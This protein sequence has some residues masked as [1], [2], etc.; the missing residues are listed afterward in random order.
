MI[1]PIIV[2]SNLIFISLLAS[3][4]FGFT[5]CS[6]PNEEVCGNNILDSN[7]S[8]D[9]LEFGNNTCEDIAS[10]GKY[11]GG[12]LDCSGNCTLDVSTCDLNY[13]Y[14]EEPATGFGTEIGDIIQ[15]LD[16][17]LGNADSIKFAKRNKDNKQFSL[18]H[19]Y[20]EN[21]NKGGKWKG[22]L[23]FFTTG[24]CPYCSV[25][26]LVL[27]NVTYEYK[28]Q[29]ILFVGI[30][31]ENSSYAPADGEYAQMLS[32]SY[33]WRFPAV[34]GNIQV[35]SQYWPGGNIG[36][37]M[38][39]LLDLDTMEIKAVQTGALMNNQVLDDFI[40]PVLN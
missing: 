24:W 39:I 12:F 15:D 27:T 20:R 19:I 26:A 6:D 33:S 18:N 35:L 7:E 36:F 11:A 32:D 5:S 40:A 29:G 31:L 14:P 25:E 2:K 28:Q 21:I 22:V 38:N 4:S 13:G 17:E 23:L 34:A 30:I 37:P 10:L 8:C 16:F 3:L 1:K 9:G